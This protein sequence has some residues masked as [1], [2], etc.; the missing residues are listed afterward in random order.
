[1]DERLE[2]IIDSE[3]TYIDVD[4]VFYINPHRLALV[5]CLSDKQFSSCQ[6]KNSPVDAL[7]SMNFSYILRKLQPGATCEVIIHQPISVMQ[8]YDA[9]QVEANAKLA[10]FAEFETTEFDFVDPK[11][12]RKNKTLCV[13]FTKPEK[14]ENEIEV[15]LTITKR[16]VEERNGKGKGKTTT[17]TTV[18]AKKK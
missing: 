15:E 12:D 14:N 7:T 9:K 5:R 10:G 18:Q 17:S 6:I 3:D 1:M 2:L 8:E 13:A 11:T 4:T 16:T